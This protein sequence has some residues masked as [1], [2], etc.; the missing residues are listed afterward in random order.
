MHWVV[1]FGHGGALSLQILEWGAAECCRVYRP[2]HHTVMASKYFILGTSSIPM[3][4]SGTILRCG[5][6]GLSLG[7]TGCIPFPS[8]AFVLV[9]MEGKC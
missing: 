5:G 2:R 1:V 9:L 6:R 4:I 7:V 8:K 3:R